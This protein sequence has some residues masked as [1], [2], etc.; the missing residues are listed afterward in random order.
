MVDY[1]VPYHELLAA[2]EHLSAFCNDSVVLKINE[3]L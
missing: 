3:A 1:I 2:C